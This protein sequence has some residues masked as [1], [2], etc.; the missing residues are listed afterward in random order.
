MSSLDQ[1]S[2]EIAA[3]AAPKLADLVLAELREKLKLHDDPLLTVAQAAK[4]MGLHRDT[5]YRLLKAKVLKKAPGL[6]DIRIRQSVL[7]AYGK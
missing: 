6:T 5:V 3:L 2:T 1:L 4:H 7:D